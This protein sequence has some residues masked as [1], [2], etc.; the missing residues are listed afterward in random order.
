[1][2]KINVLDPTIREVGFI[3]N[4]NF[5]LE[6]VQEIAKSS[7][8]AG[9]QWIEIGHG[10]GVGNTEM[11]HTH[12]EYIKAAKQVLKKAK[13][14]AFA[15]SD[16]C[17]PE[18]VKSVAEAGLDCI[19]IGFVGFDTDFP[20]SG[21]AKLVKAAKDHGLRVSVNMLESGRYSEV[22]LAK[23]LEELNKLPIDMLYVVDSP[24]AMLPEQVTEQVTYLK[25][26]S[27][28]DIGFH[29]HMQLGMA[30]ANSIAA[31]KA[32][33][34][35]VDGTLLGAGRDPGNAQIELVSAI[36]SRMGYETGIDWV[37]LSEAAQK[38]LKPLL[39]GNTALNTK[40]LS[41]GYYGIMDFA[42]PWV[43][44]IANEN[45]V[46]VYDLMEQMDKDKVQYITKEKILKSL[47]AIK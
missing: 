18:M 9:T 4:F 24:G 6:Q 5:T 33:A 19:R 26:N 34:S 22:E 21:V 13:V 14:S 11:K 23:I 2:N 12:E 28:F 39:P 32:G 29:G 43:E 45:K 35:W 17:T 16:L 3:N 37:K 36:L 42:H 38:T 7:E 8:E 1:M 20:L 10:N 44:E 40:Q 46:D 41:L 25:A 27:K 30:N 47:A 15:L 31:V